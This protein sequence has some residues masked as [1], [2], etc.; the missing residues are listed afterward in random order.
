MNSYSDGMSTTPNTTGML[1]AT[2]RLVTALHK[3]PRF[4]ATFDKQ[5]AH[6]GTATTF[7][8]N[9]L[10]IMILTFILKNRYY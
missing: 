7:L 9:I 2:A 5:P 8:I 1:P 3:V 6:F 4:N 10:I